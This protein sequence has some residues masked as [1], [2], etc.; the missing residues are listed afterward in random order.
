MWPL[1]NLSPWDRERTLVLL[2]TPRKQ[3]RGEETPVV[4][5]TF[6]GLG[7]HPGRWLAVNMTLGCAA[8]GS[9]F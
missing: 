5:C 7:L 9:P 4:T 8:A 6:L 1:A 3:E 2:S